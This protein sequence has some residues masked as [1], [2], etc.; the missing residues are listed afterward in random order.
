MCYQKAVK[1]EK[2]KY[3][4]DI[5]SFNYNKPCALFKTINSVLEVPK[6]IG[7]DASAEICERFLDFFSDNI[8]STGASIPHPSYDATIALPC[9]SVYVQFEPVSCSILEHSQSVI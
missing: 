4:S 1:A 3:F 6:Y 9:T 2:N 5:V 8:V 7:F